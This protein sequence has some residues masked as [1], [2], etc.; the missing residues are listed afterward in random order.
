MKQWKRHEGYERFD[1][2]FVNNNKDKDNRCV[3]VI[4]IYKDV[5]S[6]E[7]TEILSITRTV[8]ILGKNW[9]LSLI[10]PTKIN[11]EEYSQRFNYN[12]SYAK[13]N[14][15]FFKDYL[16]YCTLCEQDKFYALYK[17]YKYMLICQTDVYVFHDNLDYFINLDY[18][19]IGA[20]HF[21]KETGG[22]NGN[23]GF[24]LRRVEKMIEACNE[25]NFDKLP[26]LCLEDQVFTLVNKEMFN[27]A[28]IEICHNF[29]F[30]EMI[31]NSLK[32]TKN[33]YPMAV[34][35]FNKSDSTA[36]Y[37]LI[38]EFTP[39]ITHYNTLMLIVYNEGDDIMD[40]INKYDTARLKFRPLIL[41]Y[42][43]KKGDE[44][45][46]RFCIT[47]SNDDENSKNKEIDEIWTIFK[48]GYDCLGIINTNI[49][50]NEY[51]LHQLF[52]EMAGHLNNED[53]SSFIVKVEEQD[54]YFLNEEDV[55]KVFC[56]YNANIDFNSAIRAALISSQENNRLK[57]LVLQ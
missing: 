50:I 28:P 9:N 25:I 44:F 54:F 3:V 48:G 47:F 6:L 30:H 18:D 17:E 33:K 7:K 26:L 43:K 13:I 31:E 56:R 11:I 29:S 21:T 42:S 41:N 39:N 38:K 51:T 19:Y 12:F 1:E 40:C 36:Y 46:N 37:K 10:A 34:H 15:V 8:D 45:K 49:N 52:K 5:K 20:V 4:P 22:V 16:S 14:D 24:C 2:G 27:L 57:Q 55:K 35:A 32:A 53:K 23:G